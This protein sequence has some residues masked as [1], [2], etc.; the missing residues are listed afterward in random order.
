MVITESLMKDLACCILDTRLP[1]ITSL[2]TTGGERD[3]SYTQECCHCREIINY[4]VYN[5]IILVDLK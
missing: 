4:S 2:Y 3:V 1:N 5:D